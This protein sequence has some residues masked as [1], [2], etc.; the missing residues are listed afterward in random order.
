MAEYYNIDIE[1]YYIAGV[2]AYGC[3]YGLLANNCLEQ[4]GLTNP[5]NYINAGVT[6]WNL[7]L[8]RENKLENTLLEMAE[9]NFPCMDQDVLNI[10]FQEKIKIL[11]FK[12]NLMTKYF[13]FD[14]TNPTYSFEDFKQV[15]GEFEINEALSNP[16]IIHY[17]DKIK[18]WNN[19]NSPLANEW[20]SYAKK[21]KFYF[22]LFK[23]CHKLP[24]RKIYSNV[25]T[26]LLNALRQIFSAKNEKSSNNKIYKVITLFGVRF[27]FKK[28]RNQN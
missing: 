4:F 13:P 20:W 23:N 10:V 8:I 9:H 14:L 19:V 25:K 28:S 17:A 7:K 6:L 16:V 22:E 18:P 5:T 2:Y 24:F 21:S 11:P 3:R 1:N 12:Y 15:Y 26:S 27:K